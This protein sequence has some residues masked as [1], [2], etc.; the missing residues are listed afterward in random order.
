MFQKLGA[1]ND[2]EDFQ[3]FPQVIEKEMNGKFM[4]ILL[5]NVSIIS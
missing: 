5:S 1:S 2:V 4:K 3:E